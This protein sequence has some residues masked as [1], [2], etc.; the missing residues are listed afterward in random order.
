MKKELALVVA[1]L[2]FVAWFFRWDVIP[3]AN[4][5]RWG[6]AYMVNRLTGSIYVLHG[7]ERHEVTPSK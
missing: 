3:I 4:G 6:G 5:D 1:A 7:T 2:C